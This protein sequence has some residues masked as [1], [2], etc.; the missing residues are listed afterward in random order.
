[1]MTE[2]LRGALEAW[3]EW[4]AAMS[5]AGMVWPLA[6]RLLDLERMST[7]LPHRQLAKRWGVSRRKVRETLA[8]VL[9]PPLDQSGPPLDHP[10]PVRS[11]TIERSGP[12][13]DQSGPPLDQKPAHSRARVPS[14]A[15][16]PARAQGP[17]ES[18]KEDSL[19]SK[20][21]TNV[22]INDWQLCAD[23]WKGKHPQGVKLTK[24]KGIG[25]RILT[26]VKA[27]SAKEVI[28]VFEWAH[29]SA[30]PRAKWLREAG[31]HSSATTLL[32][33]ANFE[34]YLDMSRQVHATPL[35]RGE[36]R[37][38]EPPEAP[39]V[40]AHDQLKALFGETADA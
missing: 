37:Y 4:V 36:Y 27:Y 2:A 40:S 29:D 24:R 7:T 30:H 32:R 15:H 1:M 25:K 18:S 31:H 38:E 34:T 5:R 23:W 22:M 33:D 13:L 11:P 14:R 12:P 21:K 28:E 6:V 9:G 26:M 20:T 19:S 17:K 10:D 39:K 16:A 35:A 8:L 3:D